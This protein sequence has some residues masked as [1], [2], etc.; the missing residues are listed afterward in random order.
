[1]MKKQCRPMVD[2]VELPMPHQQIRIPRRAVDV[3]RE[4][5]KPHHHRSLVR[6]SRIPRR[7]IEHRRPRQIIE[8]EIQA[9]TRLQQLPNLVVRLVPSQ[10]RINLHE[11]NLRHP[12][13][14]RSADFARQQLCNQRQNSLPRP[15][16]FHDIQAEVVGLY[17][18]RKRSAFAQ[19]NNIT[20]RLDGSQHRYS[21]SCVPRGACSCTAL[22]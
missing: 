20:R 13:P 7:G 11:H 10:R 9:R 15:P 6:R 18:R 21:L 8:R 1:M 17:N 22:Q 19:W 4:C 14:Q 16:K 12:Q 2:R 3:L 5:V